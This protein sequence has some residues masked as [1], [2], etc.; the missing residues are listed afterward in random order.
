MRRISLGLAALLVFTAGSLNAQRC[1]RYEG[2]R[3]VVCERER[4]RDHDRGPRRRD[5]GWNGAPVEFGIRGGADF[6]DDQGSVGTQAR[7]PV[8]LPGAAIALAPSFDVFFGDR[9]GAAQWQANIDALIKPYQLGGLYGGGGAAF[10]RRDFDGDLS[11]ET[12][13]GFNLL[14]GIDGGRINGSALRPFAE[15]RWTFTGDF[16]AFRMTAGFNVPIS[17]R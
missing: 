5:H 6:R 14:A 10:L 16:Q 7:I 3:V 9:D 13:A 8:P 4:D 15:A 1:R 12:K 17:G 11:D 2:G